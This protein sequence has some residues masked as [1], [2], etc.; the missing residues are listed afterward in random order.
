MFL[1]AI[2]TAR[3]GARVEPGG[4]NFGLW[5]PHASHVELALI[6]GRNSQHNL[7][8]AQDDRGI[9][10]VFV[11]GI[12]PGQHYGYRVHGEW[13]PHRGLRLS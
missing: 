12:G 11:P 4:V 2:D 5:A 7:D 3:L 10:N 13:A 6:D 9:W 1:E 8:M